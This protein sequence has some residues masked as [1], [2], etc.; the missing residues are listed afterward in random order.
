MFTYSFLYFFAQ[1]LWRGEGEAGM[2]VGMGVGGDRTRDWVLQ[3]K[4]DN[5][6]TIHS[7]TPSLLEH[8]AVGVGVAVAT[9]AN[10]GTANMDGVVQRLQ[11]IASRIK[12]MTSDASSRWH[13][14]AR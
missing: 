7:S 10:I 5:G 1:A 6:L 13:T 3:Q 11:L 2:G 4:S 12:G 8:A 14:S 9:E